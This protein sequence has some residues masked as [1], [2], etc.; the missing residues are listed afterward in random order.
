MSKRIVILGSAYPLRGGLAAYNERIARAFQDKGYKV[1]IYTFSLQYPKLLFPGKSQYSD[2]PA[3]S[4]L[5]IKVC[6]NSI[7][8][9][10]WIKIGR[11]IKNLAP[12][13]LL[14]KFW[15]PFMAPCF[16]TILRIVRR[17]KKTAIISIIDNIV[18]HEKRIGD[19]LLAKY[20][21]KSVDG[22]IAMSRSVYKQLEL[23]TK[24]ERK[25]IPHPIYDHYGPLE[26]KEFAKNKINLDVNQPYILFFGFIRGYKG[27]DLL[28]DSL[29]NPLV[30]S[31]GV[32]AI[33]A[34]EFYEDAEPYLNQIKELKLEDNILMH[35]QFIPDEEVKNY[36]NAADII[37]QPYKS[38][39]QSGVTQIAYHFNK[40]M[41]VT[42]VGGLA[43]F[44]PH[45]KVGYVVEPNANDIANAIVDFYS[46]NR[47]SFFVQNVIEQKKY[48]SWD[49]MTNAIEKLVHDLK[50][51]DDDL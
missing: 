50:L 15:L 38:A 27:L 40:P 8:P 34:G 28:I 33:V 9:L 19:T 20:F 16:G 2:S 42:N 32:K 35:T 41:I 22:F 3:P 12:D 45:N 31:L 37:V 24:R 5:A 29:A 30:Q 6:V 14:V 7:N 4:D 10:N 39:T 43:E 17:N 48:Y 1:V 18:P 46:N 25:F 21:A 13:I 26:S 47:E 51:T 23:F 49:T 11:E 44:I 36:F